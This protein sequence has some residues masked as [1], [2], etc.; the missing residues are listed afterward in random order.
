M[1]TKN[2]TKLNT[3]LIK[4]P[5]LLLLY[6]WIFSGLLELK[7]SACNCSCASVFGGNSIDGPIVT[8]PAYTLPKGKFALSSGLSYQNYDEF[9][10]SQLKSFNRRNIHAHSSSATMQVS[11]NA[12]YGITDDLTV[13]ISYPFQS[14][15]GMKYTYGGFTYDEEN[16]MGL[17]DMSLLAKY[18][19]PEIEKIQLKTSLIAGLKFP[20]GFTHEKDI[21]NYRL[22]ADHQPG[23]GSWDPIFGIAISKNFHGENLKDL[24][25]HANSLYKLSTKGSQDTVVGDIVNFNFGVNYFIDPETPNIFQKLFPK[26]ILGRDLDWSLVSEVN[27]TWQEKVEY[28]GV[29]DD[30]HGGLLINWMN[31]LKLAIHKRVVLGI[32]GGFPLINDP[33]GIRPDAGFSLISTVGI[34]F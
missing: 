16:S 8:M 25:L 22:S 3:P 33:N 26:K 5:F 34:L 13:I 29:K 32:L 20:T 11:A 9:N 21:D 1:I 14:G 31:G 7:V 30:A 19:L 18:S 28:E 6:F 24:S 2:R 4:L 17:G 10:A 12:S 23:S 27:G 15:Y